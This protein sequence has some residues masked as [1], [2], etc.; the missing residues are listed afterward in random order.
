MILPKV[1]V[2]FWKA[3]LNTDKEDSSAK[4]KQ[5][6]TTTLILQREQAMKFLQ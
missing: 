6:R 5:R 3:R 4:Q 1:G 2:N